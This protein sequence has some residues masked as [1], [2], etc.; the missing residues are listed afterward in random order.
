MGQVAIRRRELREACDAALAAAVQLDDFYA[1]WGSLAEGSSKFEEV[2]FDDLVDGIEHVPGHWLRRGVNWT[3]W[4]DEPMHQ[5][6][7]LDRCLLSDAHL[8]APDDDLLHCRYALEGVTATLDDETLRERVRD[9][10]DR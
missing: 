5:V 4:S 2:V 6:L 1:R 10:L 7:R 8:E 9:C 3:A